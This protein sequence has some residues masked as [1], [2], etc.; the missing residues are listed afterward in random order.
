MNL[1]YV[2]FSE[3][4]RYTVIKIL[5]ISNIGYNGN[6]SSR[7]IQCFIT[8]FLIMNLYYIQLYELICSVKLLKLT[9]VEVI[10]MDII[11]LNI[12]LNSRNSRMAKDKQ[13]VIYFSHSVNSSRQMIFLSGALLSI[14][15]SLEY[16]CCEYSRTTEY[17][18]IISVSKQSLYGNFNKFV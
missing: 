11:N 17:L 4:P 5:D 14:N 9:T 3:V 1:Y 8:F 16:V 12:D 10:C 2:E 13:N 6:T 7:I 18:N 15:I